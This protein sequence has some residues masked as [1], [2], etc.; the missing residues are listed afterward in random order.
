MMA[1][2]SGAVRKKT[3]TPT[4]IFAAT[5]AVISK[6][7]LR[8]VIPDPDGQSIRRL[9]QPGMAEL[10]QRMENALANHGAAAD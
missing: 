9:L 8:L 2:S 3:T 4:G 6:Q 1:I 10:L 7:R 5:V